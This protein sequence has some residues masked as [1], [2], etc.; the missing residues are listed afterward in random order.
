MVSL[1]K[2][3]K[4]PNFLAQ[5]TKLPELP[6]VRKSVRATA[7]FYGAGQGMW[8]KWAQKTTPTRSNGGK[9]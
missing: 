3:P 6:D 8:G 4:I 5:A 7:G 2:L 1:P 9:G